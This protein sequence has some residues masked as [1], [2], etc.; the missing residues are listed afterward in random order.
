MNIRTTVKRDGIYAYSVDCTHIESIGDWVRVVGNN[1]V[2]KLVDNSYSDVLGVIY[3]KSSPTSCN[4]IIAGKAELFVGLDINKQRY[5]LGNLGI[6]VEAPPLTGY[7]IEL[8][9]PV[10]SSILNLNIRT[11]AKRS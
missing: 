8:G 7:I 9:R 2:S 10:T 3:G 4:V 11:I 5:F 1:K 6:I